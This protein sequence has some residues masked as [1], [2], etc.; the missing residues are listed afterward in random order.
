MPLGVIAAP[1]VSASLFNLVWLSDT[2]LLFLAEWRRHVAA[3]VRTAA[4]TSWCCSCESMHENST[5]QVIVASSW[6]EKQTLQV[7]W[8]QTI[9]RISKCVRHAWLFK[10]LSPQNEIV[11]SPSRL[12]RTWNL[13]AMKNCNSIISSLGPNREH[14]DALRNSKQCAS[15]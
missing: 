9:W 15:I 12:R 13:K 4:W 11:E 1:Y 5:G 6:I 7:H 2:M 8:R 3:G 14:T 10:S